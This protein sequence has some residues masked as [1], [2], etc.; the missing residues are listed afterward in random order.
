M[1]SDEAR[2]R[3]DRFVGLRVEDLLWSPCVICQPKRRHGPMCEAFPKK[4]PDD[5]LRDC[6]DLENDY[7]GDHCPAY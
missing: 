7:P 5:I 3:L 1:D 2:G 6:I 4:I